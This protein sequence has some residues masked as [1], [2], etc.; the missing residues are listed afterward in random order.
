MVMLFIITVV[1][2]TLY[3]YYSYKLEKDISN[4]VNNGIKEIKN[5]IA[6]GGNKE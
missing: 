5:T 2:I 1:F 4:I 3:Q 6:K